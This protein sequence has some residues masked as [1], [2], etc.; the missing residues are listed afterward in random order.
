MSDV[1]VSVVRLV[2]EGDTDIPILARIVESIADRELLVD[3]IQ[4]E[5]PLDRP[6]QYGELGSGWKGVRRWCKRQ[7]QRFGCL[8]AAMQQAPLE[9]S[10]A[11]VIH[12]DA[13]IAGHREIDCKMP[14]PPASDTADALREVV[15]GWARESAVPDGVVLCIPSKSTDAW[16]F[17]ALY[18]RDRLADSSIECRKTPETLLKQRPEKLV[19]GPEDRKTTAA[20]RQVARRVAQAWPHVCSICAQAERF[21]RELRAALGG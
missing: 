19:S 4:P 16:V 12:I 3:C 21:D 1:G 20:Y 10:A 6:E 11:L 8:S 15:L 7:S 14:C 5:R 2:C 13:D 17:V 18:P 9:E